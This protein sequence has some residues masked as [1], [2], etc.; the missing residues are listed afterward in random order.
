MGWTMAR[1]KHDFDD[2]FDCMLH[3][4]GEGIKAY[5]IFEPFRAFLVGENDIRV[6]TVQAASSSD[7]DRHFRVMVKALELFVAKGSVR[8]AG[9]CSVGRALPRDADQPIE[10]LGMNL[11]HSDGER[12]AICVRCQWG[13]DG[14]VILQERFPMREFKAG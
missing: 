10:V 7:L 12:A 14:V 2:L 5:R 6:P 9:I 3:L 8:A 4:G 1:R 11:L 13:D